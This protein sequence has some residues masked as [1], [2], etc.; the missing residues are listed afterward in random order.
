MKIQDIDERAERLGL[1]RD[2]KNEIKI[3]NI[4]STT[5]TEFL[6]RHLFKENLAL[7]NIQYNLEDN[8]CYNDIKGL[9]RC[10]DFVFK[11]I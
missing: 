3:N 7:N 8:V 4:R 2:L 11:I 10:R 5:R 1:D 6:N 9:F